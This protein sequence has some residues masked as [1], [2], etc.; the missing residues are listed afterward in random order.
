MIDRGFIQSH[1]EIFFWSVLIQSRCFPW[2]LLSEGH[3]KYIPRYLKHFILCVRLTWAT[4]MGTI[5]W[6]LKWMSIILCSVVTQALV[7][8]ICCLAHQ[9]DSSAAAAA[10][11]LTYEFVCKLNVYHIKGVPQWDAESCSTGTLLTSPPTLILPRG[12]DTTPFSAVQI[13]EHSIISQVFCFLLF[14]KGMVWQVFTH[15]RKTACSTEV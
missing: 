3:V 7:Q 12:P 11:Q 8:M 9:P 2:A 5:C 13:L 4:F 6:I 10:A 15:W 14:F 1:S